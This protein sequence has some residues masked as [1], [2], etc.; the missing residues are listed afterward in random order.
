MP[1]ISVLLRSTNSEK[2]IVN[3][4]L[5]SRIFEKSLYPGCLNVF[6][7]N[8]ITVQGHNFFFVTWFLNCAPDLLRNIILN[9]VQKISYVT[10]KNINEYEIF[11]LVQHE[12]K[13]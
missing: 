11:C 7:L 5:I 10:K 12:F 3:V 2:K 9:T 8:L 1:K 4:D 6:F 13:Y